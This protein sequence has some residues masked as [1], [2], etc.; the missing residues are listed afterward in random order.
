MAVMADAGAFRVLVIGGYGF[1]GQRLADRLARMAGVHLLIAGRNVDSARALATKLG[2]GGSSATVEGVMI[3]ID[4]AG[5]PARLAELRP[6]LV[7]HT[8]GPFQGQDYHVAEACI[9]AGAHYV[10]LADGRRFVC[11]IT[12]LDAAA[13]AAGVLVVSGASS[14]PALSGAA[15]EA[16]A[17]G[18]GRIDAIDI[19]INPGNRTE[20]GLATVRAILGYCGA[21]FTIRRGGVE[22]S[23]IGWLSS[24]RVNYPAPV[25]RRYVADCDVPDLELLPRHYPDLRDLRF[26]GGVEL[27]LLHVG[28]QALA[29]CRHKGWVQDWS[30]HATW[31]KKASDWFLNFGTADGAMHVVMKGRA[32]AG[33]TIERRWY[34]V[35]TEGDGPYVPTLAAAA[36]VRGIMHRRI[37]QHGAMSCLG[38]LHLDHILAE[39]EGLSIRTVG[40][41]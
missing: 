31:L 12:R 16:M 24:R 34:L 7:V 36:M 30:R 41:C 28:M 4:D 20:R 8:S 23:T 6:H 22:T 14:V 9:A 13:R 17:S 2:Q 35:A 10:D 29:W 32:E 15:V 33:H 3:D 11:D 38:L 40:P 19:G 18:F 37:G 5:F 1:F 26:G 27:R 21:P 25:G 39:A